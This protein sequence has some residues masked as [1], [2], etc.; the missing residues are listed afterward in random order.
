MSVNPYIGQT[1]LSSTPLSF[2]NTATS[3]PKPIPGSKGAT[4]PFYYCSTD[5]E[6]SPSSSLG[7]SSS[8]TRIVGFQVKKLERK[9]VEEKTNEA[10]LIFEKINLK[11][12][13]NSPCLGSIP[14]NPLFL[15][16]PK[17]LAVKSRLQ[18]DIFDYIPAG[19]ILL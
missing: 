15:N 3:L 5:S 14:E 17:K 2:S 18:K 19:S 9:E 16:S 11:S 7:S 10:F 12:P 6:P 13:R 1:I 8:P 4:L